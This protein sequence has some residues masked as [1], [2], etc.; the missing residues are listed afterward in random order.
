M[1]EERR[2]AMGSRTLEVRVSSGD[3]NICYVCATE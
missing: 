1:R 3:L 2:G